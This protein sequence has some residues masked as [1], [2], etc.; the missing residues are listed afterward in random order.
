[1]PFSETAK[2]RQYVWPWVACGSGLDLGCGFDKVHPRCVGVDAARTSAADAVGDIRDLSR[3]RD[4]E[5]DWV[6]SSHAIEDIADTGQA[7]REWLRVLRPGGRIVLYF[8]YR[9]YYPNMGQ[10]GANPAHVHDFAPSDI[11]S[12]LRAAEPGIWIVTAEVRGHVRTDEFHEYSCLVVAAKGR[13]DR[14]EVLVENNHQVGDTLSV[15]P[16]C[17]ALRDVLPGCRITVASDAA[18]VLDGG[19]CDSLGRDPDKAYDLVVHQRTSATERGDWLRRTAHFTQFTARACGELLPEVLRRL[20]DDPAEPIDLPYRVLGADAEGL[21]PLP[22]GAVAVAM[23]TYQPRRWPA[24]RWRSLVA[25]LLDAGVPVVAL[26]LDASEPLDARAV[27]LRGRTTFR[28]ACAALSRSRALVSV[29]TSF[30][31]V[32]HSLGV[33]AVVLMGPSGFGTTFYRDTVPVWRPPGGCVGCYNWAD[34]AEPFVWEG[35]RPLVPVPGSGHREEGRQLAMYVRP[36]CRNFMSGTECMSAVR[37][38]DAQAAVAGLLGVPPPPP[39]GVTAVWIARDEEADLPR[40]LDSVVGLADAVVVADTGSVDRTVEVA[41]EWSARTGIPLMAVRFGWRD[42]FAAAKN[43]AA[44]HVGT[45]HFIWLDADDVVEDPRA[46]RALFDSTGH[47]VYHLWTDMGGGSRFLRERIAPRSAR[48]L[49]P[50]HECLDIRG[51]DA[52]TSDLAV[53]HRPSKEGHWRSSLERNRRILDAWIAAEPESD[54]ATFYLAETKRQQGDW[55]GAAELY[56]LHFGRAADWSEALFQSA[57]QMA[58]F[59]LSRRE[60]RDAA[61]WGLKAIATDPAW[62]EGYYAV[63]DAY[64]WMGL[65]EIA[66]AWFLAAHNVPRPDRKLWKE[67]AVYGHLPATQLSY[68]CERAGNLEGAIKWAETAAGLGGPR[69]RADEL[70]AK[71]GRQIEPAPAA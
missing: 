8:P 52:A 68:C 55:P 2:V 13:P 29:D 5:F 49:Y 65:N 47:D 19:D 22:N 14:P 1:M 10:P 61:A 36:G 70:L 54:R 60:W 41:E 53:L 66:Y 11:V 57:Y 62:R 15:A 18:G 16:L 33:P 21:P 9:R 12:A 30:A 24:G 6:F 44:G 26:G 32:A 17:R 46:V 42:D 37:L 20:P 51:L 48:W 64:F 28:Q 71:L 7:L 69:A 35:G 38:Q 34:R 23:E 4:G 56:R 67:E 3:W 58:R 45:S 43:F 40:S 50:I 31:H 59:H 63:G 27:D 39:R 25:W